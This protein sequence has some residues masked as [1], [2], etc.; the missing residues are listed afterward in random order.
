MKKPDF[1]YANNKG[2]DQP[3]YPHI[4]ISTFAIRYQK[5]IGDTAH[6]IVQLFA[7]YCHL[8]ISFA[9]SLDPDQAQHVGPDL[10]L[11]CLTL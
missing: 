8:L 10:D 9:N 2:A 6:L 7:Y 1:V 3:E 4:L 5:S 11:Y